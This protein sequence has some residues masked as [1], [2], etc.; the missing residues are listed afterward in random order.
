MQQDFNHIT[1]HLGT[2]VRNKI[3]YRIL[4]F[5]ISLNR[6]V[7]SRGW[8]NNRKSSALMPEAT[9]LT[10]K[11]LPEGFGGG[12]RAGLDDPIIGSNIFS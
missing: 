11:N 3:Y 4:L 6:N 9:K 8:Y 1:K 12:I 5:T 7:P 2:Q 10:E